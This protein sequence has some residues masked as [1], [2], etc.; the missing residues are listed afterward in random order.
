MKGRVQTDRSRVG[1][2]GVAVAAAS[3]F[4]GGLASLSAATKPGAAIGTKAAEF[5]LKDQDGKTR[6]LS[7]FSDKKTVVLVFLGTACPI[8]NSYAEPVS[9]L[10]GKYGEERDRLG[11]AV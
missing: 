1:P 9:L 8:A 10:A 2:L 4:L 5:R 6:A 3:L 11:I 7:E